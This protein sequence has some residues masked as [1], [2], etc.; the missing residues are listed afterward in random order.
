MS[1]GYS[2]LCGWR[3]G[4]SRFVFVCGLLGHSVSGQA[5]EGHFR[6]LDIWLFPRPFSCVNVAS[7]AHFW[8]VLTTWSA[9]LQNEQRMQGRKDVAAEAKR[10]SMTPEQQAK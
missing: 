7:R 1:G 9:R 3:E 5:L 4:W 2:W 6:F 8:F 10:F